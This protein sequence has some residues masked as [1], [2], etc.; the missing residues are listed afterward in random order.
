MKIALLILA[1]G[2]RYWP[3]VDPLLRSVEQ[4]FPKCDPLVWTDNPDQK[5]FF[6]QK[7][8]LG[9]P[10][11]TLHRYHTFLEAE[12]FL[13]CYDYLFYVDVDMRFVAPIFLE[14]ILSD[15]ITA[16]LHPGYA[17]ARV[18]KPTGKYVPTCGLPERRPQ[19]VAYIPEGA[20]TRY[21]CGGFNGG[22]SEAYLTMART[23]RG[24]IEIDKMNGITARWH[25]ESHMNRYLLDHPP[26]KVLTPSFCYPENYDGG[27]GW[28]PELYTPKLLALD[29]G[30]RIL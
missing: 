13:K 21:F 25:D 5:E 24:N 8:G 26:A 12:R 23:I 15:G 22:T 4:F 16:T 14:D 19:S 11:E 18:H 20:S 30:P 27:Y 9:Y 2:M 7:K 28:E 10:G 3:Y 29:K 1:T 6:V 17:H